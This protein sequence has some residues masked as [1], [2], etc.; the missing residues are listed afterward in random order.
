MHDAIL[1]GRAFFAFAIKDKGDKGF[2]CLLRYPL[3][4][5]G[6][7]QD[8]T[9]GPG[10]VPLGQPCDL[11]NEDGKDTA[12]MQTHDR[13]ELI[14]ICPVLFPESKVD[15]DGNTL[16][17]CKVFALAAMRKV[18]VVHYVELQCANSDPNRM[19]PFIFV[20]GFRNVEQCDPASPQ[21]RQ[22]K[23]LLQTFTTTCMRENF[24]CG[25]LS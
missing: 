15:K 2:R 19:D 14:K 16:P 25:F 7:E 24:R 20:L 23:L 3:D 1:A 6:G 11:Q 5:P 13:D 4:T 17:K 8:D 10:R 18:F 21:I 22:Y 9:E 12:N